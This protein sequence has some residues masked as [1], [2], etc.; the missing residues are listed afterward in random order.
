MPQVAVLVAPASC[1]KLLSRSSYV[2]EN[3]DIFTFAFSDGFADT[4]ECH[5]TE[6]QCV[7]GHV[8]HDDAIRFTLYIT[9]LADQNI[10]FRWR[11]S[12]PYDSPENWCTDSILGVDYDGEVRST[13]HMILWRQ[14]PN[15]HRQRQTRILADPFEFHQIRCSD[16]VSDVDY[17]GEA[18]SNLHMI[19]WRL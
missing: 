5:K 12:D 8:D 6:S 2:F 13:L 11:L 15:K 19:L 4:L 16:T 17:D 7:T 18:R 14:E 1:S 10:V 9:V 3:S